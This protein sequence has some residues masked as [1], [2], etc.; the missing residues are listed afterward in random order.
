MTDNPKSTAQ[1]AGHPIHPMLVPFPIAFFVATFICDLVFLRNQDPE[2]ATA[3]RWLLG[4]GLVSAALAA[5]AGLTDFLGER[6][7]RSLANAWRHM[8]GNI[9]AVVIALVNF[10]VRASGGDDVVAPT[11]FILSLIVVAILLYTGWQGWEMVYR[12]RVGVA[13]GGDAIPGRSAPVGRGS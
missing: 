7:I 9:A 12:H 13:D 10:I 11:G 1:V 2:W 8:I 5:L 6:R 3:G 4:A